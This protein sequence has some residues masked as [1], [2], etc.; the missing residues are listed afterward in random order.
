MVSGDIYVL[1]PKNDCLL[2][3]LLPFLCMSERFF[4][5][6]V[7]T[8]AGSLSPRTNWSHLARFE[9]SLPPLD[10]QR[11]IAEILWTVDEGLQRLL[12]MRSCLT[13]Q[14]G[15]FVS[16]FIK[17]TAK[18]CASLG[19]HLEMVQYGTSRRA[20]L[21]AKPGSLPVLRI[22]NVISGSID[23]GNLAWLEPSEENKRYEVTRDDVLIVRTNGNPDYVGR[24]AVFDSSAYEQC[25]FAS[26]LIRLRCRDSQLLPKFLH[27]MLE[28]SHVRRDI[29][30]Q[31]KS[32][33][34]NYNLNTQGI[35]GL[36]IP[37]PSVTVQEAFVEQLDSLGDA[38]AAADDHSGALREMGSFLLNS[39][40]EG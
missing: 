35:R 1:A 10:Q 39:I 13:L 31:V 22:P 14:R 17:A 38:I 30:K 4:E 24:S 29:R 2:P 18:A 20:A 34:G 37:V 8:S 27:E 5:F 32:S 23:F 28:S 15:A 25:L 26:Y 6:A 9:F 33:A 19:D 3:E 11:C 21:E 36:R 40:L 12:E 16:E 7:E